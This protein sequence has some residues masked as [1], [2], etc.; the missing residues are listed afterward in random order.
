MSSEEININQIKTP[1]NND[2]KI[3]CKVDI[4]ILLGKLREEQKKNKKDN[5][6][7]FGL[8]SSVIIVTGVIAT[9]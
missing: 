2:T 8:L 4:N 5:I 7:L 3:P 6:V 1:V 9:L